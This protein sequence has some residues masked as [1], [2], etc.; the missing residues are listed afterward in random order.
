MVKTPCFQCRG[1]QVQ[2]LIRELRPHR[3]RV[4]W[5]KKKVEMTLSSTKSQC[6]CNLTEGNTF[7]VKSSWIK[8]RG[9]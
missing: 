3:L 1:L 5:P 9:R 2:F 6:L 8:F 7:K 4:V